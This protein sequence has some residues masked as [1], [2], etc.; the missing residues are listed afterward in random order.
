MKWYT[1]ATFAVVVGA[2]IGFL[3]GVGPTIRFFII[4][5]ITSLFIDFAEKSIFNEHR[6]QLHNLF[7][8]IPC[9]LLYLFFDMTIGAAITAGILSHILLD[10]ITPTGCRLFWPL[11][12]KRYGVRWKY[13]D[14]KAR[15]KRVLATVSLLALLTVLILLPHGPFISAIENWTSKGTGH[16]STNLTAPDLRI[17]INDPEKDVWIHPFPNGSV[18]ID[19]DDNQGGYC[20]VYRSY[21]IYY[22]VYKNASKPSNEEDKEG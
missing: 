19:V 14:N 7:T 13:T 15:E 21:P 22:P 2:V 5:I 10:C 20:T 18:F 17:T 8:I 16:N 9:I 1:H 4:T 12:D 6:R 3:L 11:Q